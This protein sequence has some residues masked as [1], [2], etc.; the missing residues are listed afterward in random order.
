[1]GTETT[2]GQPANDPTAQGRGFMGRETT[3]AASC[4]LDSLLTIHGTKGRGIHGERNQLDSLLTIHGTRPWIHGRE[5]T[6]LESC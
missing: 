6:D 3:L 4:R 2:T 1:M 5:T